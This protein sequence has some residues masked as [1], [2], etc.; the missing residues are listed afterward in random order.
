[1]AA[2]FRYAKKLSPW[3]KCVNERSN[4]VGHHVRI[5]QR[6][7]A[8]LGDCEV[9]LLTATRLMGRSGLP[10]PYVE[11]ASMEGGTVDQFLGAAVQCAVLE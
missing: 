3:Y 11:G 6:S 1:L 2:F 4:V 5:G 8:F 7:A 10:I 9:S